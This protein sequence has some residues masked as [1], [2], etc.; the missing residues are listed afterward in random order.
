[1]K[2]GLYPEVG[3]YYDEDAADFDSRYWMNPVLQQ[4]RQSFREEVKSYPFKTMLEV[5]CGTGIDLVHF[6]LT[7]PEV[8]VTGIDISAEMVR[9]SRDKIADSKLTNVQA[10]TAT[11][12]DCPALFQDQQFDLIYV[13]FGALNTVEDLSVNAGILRRML[14]PDGKL[15]VT[16]VNKWYLGGIFLEAIRLRF[17]RAI[18]RLKP[19]WGGYSAV[20]YLPSR[21]YS[22]AEILTAFSGFRTIRHHGYSILHPAWYFTGINR[23]LGRLRKILWKIDEMLTLTPLWRFGE[24]TLFSFEKADR[25][26]QHILRTGVSDIISLP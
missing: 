6:G 24:Y 20:K 5:G 26:H 13:F 22:P 7:H 16:F 17:R 14:A 25:A 4:I 18:A 21:C 2:K 8:Q 9:I 10:F 11:V 12:E 1:M 15:V 19:V 3:T 23:K